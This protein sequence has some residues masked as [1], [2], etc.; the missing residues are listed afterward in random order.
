M[1]MLYQPTFEI[2]RTGLTRLRHANSGELVLQI[3]YTYYVA[4]WRTTEPIPE[5]NILTGWRDAAITDITEGML[6]IV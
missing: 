1:R 4:P 3:Q 5:K 2:K 6:V